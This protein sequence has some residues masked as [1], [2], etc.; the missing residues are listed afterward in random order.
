MNNKRLKKI[1]DKVKIKNNDNYVMFLNGFVKIYTRSQYKKV[2]KS[3]VTS[4]I[5]SNAQNPLSKGQWQLNAGLGFSSWGLPIYVG[6]D[7]GV[8]EDIS[9]GGEFGFRSYNYHSY[10]HNIFGFSFRPPSRKDLC[11]KKPS[12]CTRKFFLKKKKLS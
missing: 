9:I 5:Y 6:V 11:R 2:T 1:L 7:Y 4:F 10:K 12:T 8:H 3:L